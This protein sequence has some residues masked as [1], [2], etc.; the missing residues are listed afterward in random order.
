MPKNANLNIRTTL[1]I[2][3]GAE[4]ILNGLGLNISS[5]VNLFLKQVIH[6]KGIPFDLRLPNQETQQAMDDI[7]NSHDLESADTVEEMFEKIGV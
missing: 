1:E 4:I 2:K 3:K 6:Y 7:N 5:A